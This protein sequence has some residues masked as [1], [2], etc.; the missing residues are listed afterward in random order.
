[1][2]SQPIVHVEIP[3]KDPQ[4]AGV[5]YA[6]VFGWQVT[7]TPGMPDYPMFKGEGGPGGAFTKSDPGDVRI[8]LASTDIDADLQRIEANGGKTLEPK[9]EIPGAGWFAVFRDPFANTVALYTPPAQ[10]G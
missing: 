10:Q 8:Y 1:M 4:A 7:Q 6:N 9:T 2:A 3:A 5:F